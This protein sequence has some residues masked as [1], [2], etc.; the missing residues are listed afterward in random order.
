MGL[1]NGALQIGR[2]ALLSYQGALQV[3]G[4]NINSA[5]SAD[6]TRLTPLL[7]PLSGNVL[8]DGLQP[9]AGVALTGIQRNID[10]ALENRVRIAVGDS[11][12]ASAV[13]ASL[14]QIEVLFD[15]VNGT[16]VG[17]VLSAFLNGFDD[18]Q[19]TPEDV[20][21]R[22]LTVTNG[23]RLAESLASLRDRLA[24]LGSDIDDQIGDLIVRAD[25]LAAQIADLNERI[26]TAEAGRPGEDTGLRDQR[27]AALREL[28][29]LLEVTVR[30]QP[31]G[32]INVYVGSETLVQGNFSRGL[33]AVTAQDGAFTRTSVAFADT[34]SQVPAGGGRIAGLVTSRDVQAF[35]RIATVDELAAAVI[36]AVN[37]I[38]ADGQGLVG[39]T[40]VTGSYG[41]G[42]T[43]A[44]LNDPAVGLP[45]LPENGSFFITVADDATGT[46]VAYQIDVDLD[47]VGAETSLASLVADVNATVSGV[48]ASITADNR[49][50]LTA[51]DGFTFTFGHDGQVPRRDTSHVLA[52][53]GINTFFTGRDARDMA[54]NDVL[55]QA[56]ALIAASSVFL[57]GDGGNAIR[58]AELSTEANASLGGVSLIG[59]YNAV[60]G[61]V[62]VAGADALS[63]MTAAAAVESSLLAQR[64]SISGVSLDEEAISLLKFERA[65]QG[66][67]R[68][69]SVVDDLI[70]Q[71]IA[72]IR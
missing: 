35:G 18:L 43:D 44:P 3:V 34:G 15:N 14:A 10:E 60:A 25:E 39:F 36:V 42:T 64:E 13:Q 23:I 65:Y 1:F 48:T 4:S 63:T 32:S 57:S 52:S 21:I 8:G 2:S 50:A 38:H 33:T 62:A 59:F 11:A 29:G 31:N 16:D 66:A 61:D 51:D 6:Y 19:N 58:I 20:A 22:G 26:S 68:Y 30:E 12:S 46:P 45:S 37:R 55:I 9:G 47:G 54:V 41:V 53:L 56:P 17:S 7:D 40:S 67:A 28:S 27:D 49:L 70:T 72:L 69:I 71:L 24:G 5:G